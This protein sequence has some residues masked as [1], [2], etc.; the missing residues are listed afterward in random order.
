MEGKPQHPD[1]VINGIAGQVALGPAPIAVLDDET[2]ISG[3]DEIAGFLEDE[4]ES[5]F[6]EQWGLCMANRCS[7][8]A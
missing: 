7:R 2:G 5:L 8:G 6:C 3:Q 1:E 4:L